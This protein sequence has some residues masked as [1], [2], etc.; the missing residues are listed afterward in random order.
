MHVKWYLVCA[1]RT[2]GSIY[3][4]LRKVELEVSRLSLR[5]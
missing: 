5:Q 4:G 3:A 2:N 1:M